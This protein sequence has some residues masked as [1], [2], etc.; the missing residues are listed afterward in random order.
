M[1]QLKPCPFCGGNARIET[2]TTA[3]E[4]EPRFRV[5][6]SKC[7]CETSWDFWSEDDAA[8]AWNKRGNDKHDIRRNI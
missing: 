4:K 5:R 8:E 7:W 3:M 1:E 2:V 6:C